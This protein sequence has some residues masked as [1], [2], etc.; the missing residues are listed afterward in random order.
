MKHGIIAALLAALMALPARA[1]EAIESVISAQIEAFLADD[2]ETAFTYASPAIR[3]VFET[4]ER[5]G[6]MVRQGYPMVWRP[7]ELE[8]LSVEQRERGLWQNVLIRDG[9][10]ALHVLEY[11][12]VQEGGRWLIN[13]VRVRKAPAGAA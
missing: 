9:E 5:F 8:F 10:G 7:A 13:A 1:D 6:R 11:Q 2:F 4:P 12:M 3:N